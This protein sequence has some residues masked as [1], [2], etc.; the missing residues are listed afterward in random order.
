M[1]KKMTFKEL[2]KMSGT[3]LNRVSIKTGLKPPYLNTIDKRNIGL[4]TLQN[5]KTLSAAL[6][7]TLDEFYQ[8]LTNHDYMTYLEVWNKFKKKGEVP[9]TE[10]QWK[11]K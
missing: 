10:Q 4:M 9:L 11:S 1:E 8:Y 5:A 6:G 2:V 7:L 3:N